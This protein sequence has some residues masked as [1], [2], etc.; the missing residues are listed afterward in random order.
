M[1]SEQSK[2]IKCSVSRRLCC[3][4]LTKCFAPG[5]IAAQPQNSLIAP[6]SRSATGLTKIFSLSLQYSKFDIVPRNFRSQRVAFCIEHL[7]SAV[8]A[9]SQHF[10]A[11]FFTFR[12][13][14]RRCEMYSGQARLCVC[15]SVCL[16]LAA[17]SHYCTDPDVTWGRIAG[18]P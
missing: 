7:S 8:Y 6:T 17:F 11:S 10:A 12:V 5:H 18:A 13:S 3:Q 15:L 2:L 16:S 14:R 4:S 9:R 1:Q